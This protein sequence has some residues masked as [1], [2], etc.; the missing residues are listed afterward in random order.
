MSFLSHVILQ[1]IHL[2]LILSSSTE[3][4]SNCVMVSVQLWPTVPGVRGSE[5]LEMS[6]RLSDLSSDIIATP[7]LFGLDVLMDSNTL[8]LSR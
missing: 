6:L 7:P 3:S 5:S 8:M 2:P 4:L 1:T